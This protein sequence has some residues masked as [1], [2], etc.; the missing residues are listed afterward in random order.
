V[1]EKKQAENAINY[2]IVDGNVL[3]IASSCNM[4]CIFCSHRF[5]PPG[6]KVYR[7][8][9]RSIAEI[10]KALPFIDP[11]RPIVIGEA[12]TRIIEGEPLTHPNLA[13]ILQLLRVSFPRTPVSLT[14]NGIL[15][16]QAL[17]E[18]LDRLGNITVNLSLNCMGAAARRSLLGDADE[19]AAVSSVKLLEAY[20]IPFN[21]SIVA[22]PQVTGWDELEQTVFYLAEHGAKT[23]RIFEPGFSR[24]AP[25]GLQFS[26]SL[27]AGLIS[28]IEEWRKCTNTPITCEPPYLDDLEAVVAGVLADSPARAAGVQG[29]DVI[30]AVNGREVGSRVEAFRRVLKAADPVVT[31]RRENG[32]PRELLL[33]KKRHQRSGLVMDYDLDPGLIEDMVRVARHRRAGNILILTSQLAGPLLAQGVA[34]FWRENAVVKLLP[35]ENDFFGGSI[36]SAGLLTVGD[37]SKGLRQY[38]ALMTAGRPDLILLPGLAFDWKGYDLTGVHYN[39]LVEEHGIPAVTL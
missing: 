29:G 17:A 27:R 15:L 34:K 7:I 5:N 36:R 30:M 31:V 32:L 26:R 35:V 25:P 6:V 28:C 20:G 11:A 10:R 21:G 19:R 13:E 9:P 23:I 1:G 22:M 2:S 24:L 33:R 18:L 3:P 12:V 4:R 39:S 8:P 37:M 14:T 38:L 16:D